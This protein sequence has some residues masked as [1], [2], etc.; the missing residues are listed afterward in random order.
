MEL[1]EGQGEGNVVA[2]KRPLVPERPRDVVR[3]DP[4]TDFRECADDLLVGNYPDMSRPDAAAE[5]EREYVD[6]Y[7]SEADEPLAP[8][9]KQKNFIRA[10][11]RLLKIK[12]PTEAFVFKSEAMQFIRM[13]A[14]DLPPIG[15]ASPSENQ[16]RYA[17]FISERTRVEIPPHVEE[18]R[19]KL[20][21]WIDRYKKELPPS[22]AQREYAQRLAERY[23]G[24]AAI[25]EPTMASHGALGEWITAILAAFEPN[26][27]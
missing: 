24:G 21:A 9:E 26:R 16:L 1:A 5:A 12:A 17:R 3:I 10:I 18:D 22:D 8:T 19:Y 13:H 11:E 15:H 4:E 20:S 6:G 23:L 27:R 25:P 7:R 14:D 2:E